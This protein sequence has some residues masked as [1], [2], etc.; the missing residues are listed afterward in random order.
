V[1][2]VDEELESTVDAEEAERGMEDEEETDA[3]RTVKGAAAPGN[4]ADEG[5][6][7]ATMGGENERVIVGRNEHA[8]GAIG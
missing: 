8:K 6:G 5:K 3:G 4:E 2:D 1:D 7:C